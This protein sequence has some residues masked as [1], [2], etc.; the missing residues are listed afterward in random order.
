M[1]EISTYD[2]QPLPFEQLAKAIAERR[3]LYGRASGLRAGGTPLPAPSTYILFG[4]GFA[5]A[6]LIRRKNRK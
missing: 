4:A 5:I 6:G 2:G 3:S 1:S